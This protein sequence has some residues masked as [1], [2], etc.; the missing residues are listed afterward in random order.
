M[1]K[2]EIK[3]QLQAPLT[4][5]ARKANSAHASSLDFVPGTTW[6]GALA[7]AYLD[8]L[9]PA[10][11]QF[12]DWFTSGQ[13][14]FSDLLPGDDQGPGYPIPMTAV[15]CKRF[16]G[17]KADSREADETHGVK[18]TLIPGMIAALA[19][20]GSSGS[21]WEPYRHCTA[22]GCNQRLDPF[23]G[24]YQSC[25]GSY[26][27]LK[28]QKAIRAGTAIDAYTGTVRRGVLFQNDCLQAG[29]FLYG[30]ISCRS[31]PAAA[32]GPKPAASILEQ[33]AQTLVAPDT[34]VHIGR[35]VSRGLGD[36]RVVAT[37]LEKEEAPSGQEVPERCRRFN[38]A[39]AE[40]VHLPGDQRWF[41]LTLQSRLI[42]L[43][44]FL[45]YRITI[46]GSYLEAA[47]GLP[48]GSV[49]PVFRVVRSEIVSGWNSAWGLPK[50]DELA[51]AP[52]S[53]LA[54]GVD[55]QAAQVAE[56]ELYARL[57]LL[58]E[59]G[60]GERKAEGFGR[61]TICDPFHWEVE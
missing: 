30:S 3:L 29:Q 25:E 14:L 23:S 44:D 9:G 61:V 28:L 33:M 35:A 39:I 2:L 8:R 49:T 58:E 6:R 4:V 40:H 43:D 18:D 36:C 38:Q 55:L 59:Q 27:R 13:L 42:V 54:Y 34:H 53:V 5:M 11:A 50:E 1:V 16:G 15:S 21:I 26:R 47:L 10:D 19:G 37:N 7:Q 48:A 51:L 57:S 56:D 46:D 12:Q 60:I 52:G 41:A 32:G 20:Q 31:N 45:R 24:W 22:P 17:F